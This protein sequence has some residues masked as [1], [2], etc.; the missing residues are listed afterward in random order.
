MNSI[1]VNN[2]YIGLGYD[3]AGKPSKRLFNRSLP[4]GSLYVGYITYRLI[5]E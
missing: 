2:I 1:K 4:S 3:T 5:A